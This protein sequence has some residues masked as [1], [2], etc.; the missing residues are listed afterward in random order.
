M[1]Q[2]T[3]KHRVCLSKICY[4]ES[5]D[6]AKKKGSRRVSVVL[7]LPTLEETAFHK[8]TS[9]ANHSSLSVM[10]CLVLS[11]NPQVLVTR[12]H[13]RG[14]EHDLS[15]SLTLTHS[16][17]LTHSAVM[18]GIL[19][20]CLMCDGLMLSVLKTHPVQFSTSKKTAAAPS[21]IQF[22]HVLPTV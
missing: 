14:T 3:S 7:A 4:A 2:R 20:S 17:S 1:H 10:Y 8:S 16:L 18:D 5:I 6:P 19:W 13:Q 15:L 21:A 12:H 11:S 9:G 22:F